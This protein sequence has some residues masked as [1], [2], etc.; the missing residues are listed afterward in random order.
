M[1]RS[2]G[3][4]VDYKTPLP[5]EVV[6]GLCYISRVPGA[7]ITEETFDGAVQFDTV[8]G[9]PLQRLLQDMTC[10]HAPQIALSTYKKT[11]K[12]EYTRD[13]HWF[14]AGLTAIMIHWSDQIKELLNV[15]ETMDTR[16][17]CGPL[18][19]IA[20]WKSLSTKLSEISKQLQKTEIQDIQKILQLA[21]SLYLKRFH[22][23]A[24]EIQAESNLTF[25][26]LLKNPCEELSQLQPRQIASKLRH[27]VVAIRTIWNN[28]PHYNSSERI[29]GLFCQ[30][31]NEIIRLCSQSICL[32]GIFEGHLSSSRR[33]LDDC[34]Q[35]CL[36]WKETYL[37]VSQLHHK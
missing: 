33:V 18:Q 12:D 11:N 16:D 31:S 26:S 24:T 2:N 6:E 9:E 27:I 15:Q 10:L 13:M 21:K 22:E 19:E 14:I 3:L 8:R 20:F 30:M 29:T 36:S 4:Q 32:D 7:I 35:C 28:S 25:L 34:I 37:H 1:H 5:G 23:L 17:N